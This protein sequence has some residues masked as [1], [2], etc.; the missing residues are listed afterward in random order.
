MKR[1]RVMDRLPVSSTFRY[2]DALRA[3]KTAPAPAWRWWLAP[4]CWC[5]GHRWPEDG[6]VVPSDRLYHCRR[7]GEEFDARTR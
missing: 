7:C 1:G 3:D 6:P 2:A 4:L 5:A